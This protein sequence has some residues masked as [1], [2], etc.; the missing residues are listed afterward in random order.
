MPA[1]R[2]QTSFAGWLL[3]LVLCLAVSAYALA[4]L[5]LGE[6]V[7]PPNL[8]AGFLEHQGPLKL[9]VAGGGL[10]LA[11]GPFLIGGPRAR[12]ARHR[13]LGKLYVTAVLLGG[14]G[15]L[16]LAPFSYGGWVT[17]LGFGALG[18]AWIGVTCAAWIRIRQGDVAGHRAWMT[19]SFLLTLAAVTLRIYLPLAGLLGVSFETSYP[20]ISWLCWVPN[21]LVAEL[22]VRRP[23]WS[24]SPAL[25][26]ASSA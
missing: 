5:V 16:S 14:T 23:G 18:I 25:G 22:L 3:L 12:R 1:Q 4:Y 9:H 19:R 11:L 7:Y 8:A 10:A 2:V 6:R 26:A 21:L 17:H 15:G 13:V 20:F 24:R